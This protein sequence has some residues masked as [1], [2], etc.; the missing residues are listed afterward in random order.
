MPPHRGYTRGQ[1]VLSAAYNTPTDAKTK[2]RTD[3]KACRPTGG[4][5]GYVMKKTAVI[6]AGVLAVAVA[7]ACAFF[8]IRAQSGRE[9]EVDLSFADEAVLHNGLS[10]ISFT[11]IDEQKLDELCAL[12]SGTFTVKPNEVPS[13]PFGDAAIIFRGEGREVSIYPA[14]DSC[15]FM[16]YSGDSEFYYEIDGNERERLCGMLAAYGIFLQS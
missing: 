5:R 13:C 14:G 11:V 12:C 2:P 16:K 3:A 8:A 10:D 7:A 1:G 15:T 6:V 4:E 9:V